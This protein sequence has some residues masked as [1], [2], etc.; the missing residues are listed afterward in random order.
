MISRAVENRETFPN[1]V[2]QTFVHIA[3]CFDAVLPT[4]TF[5]PSPTPTHGVH[6]DTHSSDH[7]HNIDRQ[8]H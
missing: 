5:R 7:L 4:T 8:I 2:T 6:E 1:N 3:D